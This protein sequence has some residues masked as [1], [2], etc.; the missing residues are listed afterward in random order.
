MKSEKHKIRKMK[1]QKF[2]SKNEKNEFHKNYD[3]TFQDLMNSFV[4]F[5]LVF[6]NPEMLFL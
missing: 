5:F 3:F 1:F 2:R 4:L 6:Q